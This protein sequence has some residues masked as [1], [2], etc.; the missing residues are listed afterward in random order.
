MNLPP[1]LDLI[2]AS[3]SPR[4]SLLLEQANIP[5]RV[6]TID[7]EESFP[8]DM[9]ALDVAPFLAK[10]KA[11]AAAELLEANHQIV[12]T[13]D[14]VVILNETI[15]GKPADRDD[16]LRIISELSGQQHTVV[17]GVCLKSLEREVILSGRSDV[18]FE[19]LSA[20]EIAYYVDHFAPYDKAG[21]YAIQEW[22]GLCKVRKIEG[23]YHNIMGLPVD[24]VYKCLTDG[25]W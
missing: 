6:Q 20:E 25:H 1:N 18:Y 12:L 23:T 14:S 8:A 9:Q 24:L 7:V 17:T 10:K 5:F 4:R 2:L 11:L 13:A 19:N 15:Y 3:K 21:A 16:A 22:I